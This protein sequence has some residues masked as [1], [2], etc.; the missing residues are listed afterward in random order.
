[1]LIIID[2]DGMSPDFLAIVLSI[3]HDVTPVILQV[4]IMDDMRL[5]TNSVR[6]WDM[7]EY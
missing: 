5:G 3:E 6:H 4:C 2:V 1:M 7:A